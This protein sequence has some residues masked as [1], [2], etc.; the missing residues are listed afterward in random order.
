MGYPRVLLGRLSPFFLFVPVALLGQTLHLSSAAASPGEHVSVELSFKSP[1]GEE[2]SALQWETT[3]PPALLNFLDESLPPGPTAKAA[4]KA[5]NCA[6]KTKTAEVHTM[7]CILYGGQEPIQD[8]VIAVL[9]LAIPLGARPGVARIRV[10]QG[11]AVSKNLK[12]TPLDA[13]ESVVTI[14]PTSSKKHKR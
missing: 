9:R 12:K 11:L 8:G 14:H 13:V 4:G 7:S 6:V 5:V 10:D 2:P 1:R 3:L